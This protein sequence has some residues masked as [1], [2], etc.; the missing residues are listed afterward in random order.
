MLWS[1]SVRTELR[2]NTELLVKGVTT[3]DDRLVN[4]AIRSN[5]RVRRRLTSANLLK[6]LAFV[7]NDAE[8]ALSLRAFVEAFAGAEAAAQTAEDV[9]M[10]AGDE[11]KADSEETPAGATPTGETGKKATPIRASPLPEVHAYLHLLAL[12]QLFKLH[13]NTQVCCA[14]W[15]LHRDCCRCRL[16]AS[17]LLHARP[18]TLP[19]S[20]L[21]T[22]RGSTGVRLTSSGRVRTQR[23][24]W[25]TR[26]R[27]L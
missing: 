5:I 14:F 3:N 7:P 17:S 27:G 15:I 26:S 23:Y 1:C 25:H 16:T 9:D 4:K 12:D 11:T 18:S 6:A 22:S 21:P 19:K 13:L 24:P 8:A 20:W 10:S 2:G